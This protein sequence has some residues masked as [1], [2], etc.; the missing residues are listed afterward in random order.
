MI[1]SPN[2]I[3]KVNRN[4]E[5][6]IYCSG[7]VPIDSYFEKIGFADVY[8]KLNPDLEKE[9]EN[10]LSETEKNNAKTTFE[11]TVLFIN[12][13]MKDSFDESFEY[14]Y[15]IHI[16]FQRKHYLGK[17]QPFFIQKIEDI[18]HQKYTI[19]GVEYKYT[20][21]WKEKMLD[22]YYLQYDMR[23]GD[24]SMILVIPTHGVILS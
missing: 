9:I 23:G 21:E 22:S 15:S 10:S 3:T 20:R 13:F 1:H 11:K 7:S 17:I 24:F 6:T 4:S 18:E 5:W 2:T 8:F 12:N 16:P 19:D 14:I